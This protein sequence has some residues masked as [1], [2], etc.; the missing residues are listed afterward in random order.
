MNPL[1]K[2]CLSVYRRL[3]RAY[4]H[5]FQLVYGE[6]LE[7][8][9]EDALPEIWKR[10][11][12]WG[13]LRFLGD[14]ALRLPVEYLSELRH[15]TAFAL[16]TLLKSRGF[17]LAAVLSLGIGIGLCSAF[18]TQVDALL[19][20]PLPG[21]PDVAELVAV[22]EP[23]SYPY[24]ERVRDRHDIV[25]G[26]AALLAPVPF[27]V[28]L[29]SARP[30]R[31]FG[32]LVSP[33]YFATLRIEPS[34]GRLFDP[35]TE[36]PGNSPVVVLS[37]R[38]WRTH[39]NADPRVVGSTIRLNGKLAQIVGIGP[40][41]F[42]GVWPVTP[43]DLFVPI[44]VGGAVAPELT[45][46]SPNFRVIMRLADGVTFTSAQAALDTLRRTAD[47]KKPDDKRPKEGRQISL[48]SAGGVIAMTPEQRASTLAV[49]FVLGGLIL[50]LVSTNLAGLL[51]ARGSERAKEIA[52]RVAMGA[53][54]FRL[55]RQ[56]LTESTLLSLAGGAI[57]VLCG[58]AILIG[59]TALAVAADSG[60]TPPQE[61]DY[62]LNLTTL[63]FTTAIAIAAGFAFGLLPALAATRGDVAGT[64][65]LSSNGAS[66]IYRRFGLRNLLVAGQVGLSLTVVLIT[67]FIVIGYQKFAGIDPGF[68]PRDLVL[69]QI[70]PLHDGYTSAALVDRLPERL[71][72]LSAV[73]GVTL[74]AS[75]PLADYVATPNVRVT[76]DQEMV[77]VV[78]QGIG[79]AYFSTLGIPLVGGREFTEHEGAEPIPAILNQTAVRDLFGPASPVGQA[80]RDA[81]GKQYTVIGVA[82]DSRSAYL[83]AKPAATMY[84]PLSVGAAGASIIVRGVPG[85][86]TMA[87]IRDDVARFDPNLTLINPRTMDRQLA[88]MNTLIQGGS[89]FYAG[90]GFF[91][92]ILASVGLAGVTACAVV[93]RRKEIGIRMALGARRL[94]VLALVL[95][96]GAAL[97]IAGA[98]LGFAGEW[99]ASRI[100]AG[101]MSEL[102][103]LT[104]TARSNPLLSI[105]A[106]LLLV[107]I[108]MAAC[109]IPARRSTRIDPV[110]ALREE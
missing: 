25:S 99:A 23:V 92:L 60:V 13:I 33:G 18:F 34:I 51:V 79:A 56:L 64:L 101:T 37:E 96:E 62:S 21:V 46:E 44:T 68:E 69:F 26:A 39:M 19:F 93:R 8:T 95:K 90:L 87:A 6:E 4:P 22:Q 45:E 88:Q 108:T 1:L 103:R 53:S 42:L 17:T 2:A 76:A 105:G 40:K 73:R 38:Y 32:Q 7:L 74:A 72:R 24:F 66:R 28:A 14:I 65:K 85:Q 49:T 67:G 52:V 94:Q 16:R 98:I 50:A 77:G 9:G 29:N 12:I 31:I 11:G 57:G 58:Q 107:A 35:Q 48:I 27:S 3:A 59:I 106:P 5:E 80:L 47:D 63:L 75:S 102:A 110:T 81:S 91:S 15:D 78:R 55:M 100:M 84:V 30:Q 70:D 97:V 43:A 61:L 86:D 109:Y 89:A 20:R 83:M 82:R 104:D 54:R 41:D 36:Q 10:H 71:A